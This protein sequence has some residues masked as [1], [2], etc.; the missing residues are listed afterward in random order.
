VRLE[1]W[2]FLILWKEPFRLL[3]VRRM[4]LALPDRLEVWISRHLGELDMSVNVRKCS[5]LQFLESYQ[6]RKKFIASLEAGD[7]VRMG[8][9]AI[10]P[11][12]LNWRATYLRG[13]R[14]TLLIK[15]NERQ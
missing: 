4:L 8:T 14:A 7:L 2:I 5:S 15:A 11:R 6:L 13:M 3:T 10:S 9:S 12:K 1:R